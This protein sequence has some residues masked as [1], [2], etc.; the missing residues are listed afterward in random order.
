MPSFLYCLLFLLF[1]YL[2]P[3][4]FLCELLEDLKD[5][6]ITCGMF[7]ICIVVDSLLDWLIFLASEGTRIITLHSLI[8]FI[9]YG[10]GVGVGMHACDGF[11]NCMLFG[12]GSS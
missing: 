6:H 8:L 7:N 2:L 12:T 5:R 11:E 3:S 4:R 9:N 1:G 10:E